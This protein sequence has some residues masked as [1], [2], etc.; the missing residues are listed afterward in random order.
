YIGLDFYNNALYPCWAD[1]SNST[2]DNPNGTSNLDYYTARVTVVPPAV[3]PLAIAGAHLIGSSEVITLTW[4][5]TGATVILEG[6]ATFPG[7]WSTVN[8]PRTTN[9]NFVVTTVTNSAA[10]QFYRLRR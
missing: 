4:T 3:P 1:D 7:T 6:T 2:G 5:N 8:T 9:S 10:A